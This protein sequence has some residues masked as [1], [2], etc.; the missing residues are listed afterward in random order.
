MSNDSYNGFTVGERVFDKEFGEVDILG[1]DRD[2]GVLIT[3]YDTVAIRVAHE[4]LAKLEKQ[5]NI[6]GLGR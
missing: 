2:A 3:T 1:V 6:K 4:H 5:T